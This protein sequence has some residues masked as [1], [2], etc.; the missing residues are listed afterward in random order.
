MTALL[1]NSHIFVT[2]KSEEISMKSIQQS[3][4]FV[5]TTKM[6]PFV[7]II[8]HII[9][10]KF[11]WCPSKYHEMKMLLLVTSGKKWPESATLTVNIACF[12]FKVL[13]LT[14]F[15]FKRPCFWFWPEKYQKLR[16]HWTRCSHMTHHVS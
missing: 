7:S 15:T 16:P 5:I 14:S 11:I 8:Q 4:S 6:G 10:E 3:I 13:Q 1:H 9:L 12:T 2:Q